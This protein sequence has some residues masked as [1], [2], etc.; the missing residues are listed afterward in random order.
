M[1]AALFLCDFGTSNLHVSLSSLVNQVAQMP[2][3]IQGSCQGP[4]LNIMSYP[5]GARAL[6]LCFSFCRLEVILTT[7]SEDLPS[8]P[9]FI[10]FCVLVFFLNNAQGTVM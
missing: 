6:S 5:G 1:S 3:T 2:H 9:G 10:N 8:L 4:A 7:L